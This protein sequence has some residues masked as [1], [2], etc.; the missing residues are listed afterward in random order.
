ML[1]LKSEK[2]VPVFRDVAD[3]RIVNLVSQ[4]LVSPPAGCLNDSEVL[5]GSDKRWLWLTVYSDEI[6]IIG[7]WADGTEGKP[8]A[9][10]DNR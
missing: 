6:F 4:I 1:L 8:I 10:H 7:K 5:F 9:S 2:D 3:Q